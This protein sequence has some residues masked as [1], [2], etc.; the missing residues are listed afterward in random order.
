MTLLNPVPPAAVV[1]VPGVVPVL[2]SAAEVPDVSA[3]VAAMNVA[4]DAGIRIDWLISLALAN[5]VV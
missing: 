4:I 3:A 1:A 5:V 2:L